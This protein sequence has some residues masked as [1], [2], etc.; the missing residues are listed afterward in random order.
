MPY[1]TCFLDRD[2]TI[3]LPA[4]PG[5]YITSPAQLRLVPGAAEAIRRL[6]EAGSR[7]IVVTNQRGVSLG[8][9]SVEDVD[10]IHRRLV[11]LLDREGARVDAILVCP[12][13]LDT[14]DCRK[15]APGL[16]LR[17]AADEG[18]DLGDAVMV[19]DRCSD[20]AAGDAAGVATIKLGALDDRAD[21]VALDLADA[22]D[23]YLER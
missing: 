3:N 21:A 14:C 15:P 20:V 13:G 18:L 6:N 4:P 1:S 9:M 8:L 12:H 11:E 7:V 19:G 16:L 2:G 17:A 22:V 5:Q 23:R 10:A